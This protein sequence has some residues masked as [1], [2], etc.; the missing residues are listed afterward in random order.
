MTS[1]HRKTQAGIKTALLM[2]L[3]ILLASGCG[4]QDDNFFSGYAEADYVRLA[5]P[6][7]GTLSK[8]YVNRGDKV[9]RGAPAFVLE[10]ESERAA[11]AEALSRIERA[12]AQLANLKKGKRP[13]EI[14]AVQAQLAQAQAAFKLSSADLERQKKLV[15]AKFIAP[16]K[17]D[18]TRAAFERDRQRVSELQAQLRVAQQGAR[19]D[20][21]AAAQE[22]VKA[23]QAELAQADWKLDQKSLRIPVDADVDDVY[24]REGE[25]V[26]AGSPVVSLLP[27]QNIK[28]RFFV[29]EAVLGKLALGGDV[30][31]TCDHC[32]TP[33][34]AKI[35]YVSR[36]AE[37]TFPLI[38]SKEN[39]ST[40]VFMIEA[41]PSIENA[42][43]L[44]PGQPVE[45][46][47]A[48]NSK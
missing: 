6:I 13:D 46:R 36:Q 48:G 29:A 45:V 40:L 43:R 34:P 10:Q 19:P 16:E 35:S 42:R 28:L 22:D 32:G 39:R 37:Y 12:Q 2:P 44:H 8:L 20:E 24:Y 18:E 15:A 38:Y 9:T 41:R 23:A 21:I 26:A 33:I 27:P 47:L 11:R 7:A 14:A 31:V 4:K 5:S 1:I 17:L 3:A 25:L 30:S